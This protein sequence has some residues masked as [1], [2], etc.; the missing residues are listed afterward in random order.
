[1]TSHTIRDMTATEMSVMQRPMFEKLFQLYLYDYSE[2]TPVGGEWGDVDEDGRFGY[3]P[4]LD[5][6]WEEPG[7]V[8][9]LIRADGRIAGFV[10]LHQWSAL[11]QPLDRAV[12]K[13]F[14]LRKYRLTRIGTR[15]AHH[16][17]QRYPGRWE[18]AVA[19]YNPE[20]LLF[21][22]SAV[23]SLGAADIREHAGDGR[24]WSGTVLRFDTSALA[25]G[26]AE[27]AD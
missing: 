11:D 15:A 12:A 23:R 21:W 18:V 22:R 1:M 5:S 19:D 9:L 14:V 3:S 13:F 24:R 17:F 16:V 7:R 27:A 25:V 6:Y 26:I 20:A 8:P 10:L 4:G 2:R